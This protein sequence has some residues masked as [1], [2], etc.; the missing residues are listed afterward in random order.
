MAFLKTTPDT[1]YTTELWSVEDGTSQ[2]YGEANMD[3]LNLCYRNNQ[4]NIRYFT[5]H[6]KMY[7][8]YGSELI[9]DRHILFE[10][11]SPI[12]LR[13]RREKGMGFFSSTF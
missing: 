13:R 10:G 8:H 12:I 9:W 1:I 5:H 11:R 6:V 4:Y 2:V 7:Y 3:S